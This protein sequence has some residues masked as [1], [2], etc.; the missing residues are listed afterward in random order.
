M[1]RQEQ[2]ER[3]AKMV[4][5]H[6]DGWKPAAIASYFDLDCSTVYHAINEEARKQGKT[7]K[8]LTHPTHAQS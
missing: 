4:K 5:L 7:K 1:T 8:S 6:N 2:Y 3:R